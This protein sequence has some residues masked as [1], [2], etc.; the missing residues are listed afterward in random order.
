LSEKKFLL[1]KS[2]LFEKIYLSL[3]NQQDQLAFTMKCT[4]KTAMYCYSTIQSWLF[5][6]VI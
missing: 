6:K 2:V 4:V 5:I 3:K 1:R